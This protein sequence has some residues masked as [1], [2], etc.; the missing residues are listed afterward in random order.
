[1]TW[2]DINILDR[3]VFSPRREKSA[4]EN[5]HTSCLDNSSNNGVLKCKFG[6]PELSNSGTILETICI[7]SQMSKQLNKNLAVIRNWITYFFQVIFKCCKLIPVLIGGI[8]IQGKRHGALD[9]VASGVM[10]LGLILFTLADS[11]VKQI[12]Y[13]MVLYP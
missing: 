2:H 11:K 10:C 8:L 12:F 13:E 3:D 6:I 7:L 1:M 4:S 5:L 9:F